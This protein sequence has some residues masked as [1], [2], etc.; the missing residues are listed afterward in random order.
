MKFVRY[1]EYYKNHIPFI[2]DPDKRLFELQDRLIKGA[3]LDFEGEVEDSFAEAGEYISYLLECKDIKL[4][5]ILTVVGNHKRLCDS[6][7]KNIYERIANHPLSFTDAEDFLNILPHYRRG[8]LANSPNVRHK[9]VFRTLANDESNWLALAKNPYS[10]TSDLKYLSKQLAKA[11]KDN[12]VTDND[13]LPYFYDNKE[14]YVLRCVSSIWHI[15]I[16]MLVSMD[17]SKLEEKLCGIEIG[18]DPDLAEV[19][20]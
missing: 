10:Y 6:F 19:G 1:E 13:K 9:S 4:K 14:L 3:H 7:S 5:D 2:K 15:P 17:V 16:Y 8:V 12:K 11:C 20:R 18:S